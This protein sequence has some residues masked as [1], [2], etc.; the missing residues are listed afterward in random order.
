MNSP[1]I[2]GNVSLSSLAKKVK[3]LQKRIELLEI[4]SVGFADFADIQNIVNQKLLDLFSVQKSIN[5]VEDNM[6]IVDRIREVST[7][8]REES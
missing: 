5:E 3:K 7:T 6:S 1:E 8:A 2:V 4:N